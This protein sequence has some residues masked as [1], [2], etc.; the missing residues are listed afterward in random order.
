MITA[1]GVTFTNAGSGVVRGGDGGSGGSGGSGGAGTNGNTNG[2]RGADG[3]GGN[4]GAGLIGSAGWV[5]NHGSITGGHGAGANGKGGAG[6]IGSGLSITNSGTISGGLNGSSGQADAI[7][8][9]GGANT[10][11][12]QDGSILSGNVGIGG[13][14]SLTLDQ[15]SAQTLGNVITGNGSVIQNGSGTLILNGINTYTGGTTVQSGTLEVGDAAH[16]LAS[17]QGGVQVNAAGTLRGHGT[18]GG[19]VNN[20]GIVWPGGSIGTLTIAGNYT[21]SPTSTL[22]IDVSPTAASQLRVGGTASLD[23]TLD[24]LYGPGTYTPKDYTIVSA[25]SVSGKFAT[26]SG[27]APTGFAQ[28]LVYSPDT[29]TLDL[30]ANP[31][32]VLPPGTTVVVLPSGAKAFVVAPVNATIF[33]DLGSAAL[34]EAQRVNGALL[35]RLGRTCWFAAD[36]AC[37]QPGR[38]LWM[39]A[40]GTFSRID[41]NRGAPD[42]RDDR[43]GFLAGADRA[44]GAWTVGLA[45]GYS[46]GDIR[47]DPDAA[48]GKIDTLRLAVY[49]GRRLGVFDIAGTAGYAYDF[50]S[51]QRRFGWL[52]RTHGTGHAQEFNAGLQVSLPWT[53]RAT[54]NGAWTLTPHLGLRYAHVD[55]FGLSESGLS[56]QRL[57]VGDQRLNSLQPYA[58]LTLDYAFT[59]HGSA[60]PAHVGLQVGYAYETQH[61]DHDVSVTSADGTGFVV[62]GTRDTRGLTTAGLSVDVPLGRAASLYARYD[63]VLPTGNVR[64]QAVQA[65]VRYRF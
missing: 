19:D 46:H 56:S 51:A 39:Q 3:E 62:P 4:G 32:A 13:N 21:Q 8:F 11:M 31:A 7:D 47:E 36:T 54:E 27:N 6:I 12:L 16:P 57:S 22:M 10:L 18:V 38:R 26:V 35:D 59:M 23:G 55:G 5:I 37:T 41:G 49:G 17:V 63:A 14:G 61:R 58:G 2:S 40:S 53:F 60:R 33:G 42:V 65:G 28:N 9:V 44:L 1:T 50:F 25:G 43:Y 24:L 20:Q 30:A 29:V 48:S 34:R 52:G 45:G 64:A 15:S